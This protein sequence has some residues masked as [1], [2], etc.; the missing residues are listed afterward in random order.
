MGKKKKSSLGG[1][2]PGKPHSAGVAAL[3][4]K[5]TYR[6]E[7]I[8]SGLIVGNEQLSVRNDVRVSRKG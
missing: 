2:A 3:V 7:K 8:D 6:G 5:L 4:G 1:K